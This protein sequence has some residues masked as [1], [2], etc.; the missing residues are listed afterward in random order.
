MQFIYIF[1]YPP[2]RMLHFILSVSFQKFLTNNR[3]YNYYNYIDKSLSC[4]FNYFAL[5]L[6]QY[7]KSS[8]QNN[9]ILKIYI[10]HFFD[11]HLMGHQ[12]RNGIIRVE[13]RT[14]EKEISMTRQYY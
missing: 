9:L 10:F 6:L 11:S 5:L 2:C 3:K 14:N 12:K 4:Q 1:I 13:D 7:S 8:M